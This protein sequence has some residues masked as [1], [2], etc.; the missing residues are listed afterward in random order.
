MLQNKFDMIV[1]NT[2]VESSLQQASFY[3]M[4]HVCRRTMVNRIISPLFSPQKHQLTYNYLLRDTLPA[5][6]LSGLN[7]SLMIYKLFSLHRHKTLN[8]FYKCRFYF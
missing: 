4:N 1:V 8:R 7:S 5:Y 2:D 6:I 3:F